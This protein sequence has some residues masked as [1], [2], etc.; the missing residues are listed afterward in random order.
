[1]DLYK[2]RLRLY[3]FLR[4]FS[5]HRPRWMVDFAIEETSLSEGLRAAFTCTSMLLLGML[6]HKREFSWAAIGALWTCLADAAGTTRIRVI[7]MLSFSFLSTL[8]GGITA[9]ASSFGIV[10]SA[11][12]I[13]VFSL[14]AGLARVCSDAAYRVTIVVATACIVM[15]Y[16]PLQDWHDAMVFLGIYLGGCLFALLLSI[17]IWQNHRFGPSRVA[18]RLTFSRISELAWSTAQLIRSKTF[19]RRVWANTAQLHNL[20]MQTRSTIETVQHALDDLPQP[21]KESG[22][23]VYEGLLLALADAEKSFE[24][25]M[26]IIHANENSLLASIHRLHAARCLQSISV[27]L[28]KLGMQLDES[29]SIYPF[30]LRNRLSQFSQRLEAALGHTVMLRFLSTKSNYLAMHIKVHGFNQ[31]RSVILR[32]IACLRDETT[33]HSRSVQFAFRLAIA[34]TAAFVLVRLLHIHNGYWATMTVLIILQ[35]SL[36]T[37]WPRSIERAVGTTLGAV[38]AI[39]VGFIAV[40]PLIICLCVFLL[41]FL[42]MALRRVN[43]SLYVMFLT[44]SFVLVVNYAFPGNE[45]LLAVQ[46]LGDTILGSIIAILATY[47]LW[48]NRP[49]KNPK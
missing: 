16:R 4:N 14:L 37:A 47:L 23:N 38:I 22:K 7:S 35:P 33:L 27:I 48:P 40:T 10:A 2:L 31:L 20:I 32:S 49:I 9:H 30:P 3:K 39:A 34:T 41:I 29:K 17:T 15:V 6:L 11:T 36:T 13:F 1:M 21:S 43:Y 12:A 45:I 46:R 26:A 42:S 24:S 19:D 28:L 5:R 25:L 44:P 8:F 18:L